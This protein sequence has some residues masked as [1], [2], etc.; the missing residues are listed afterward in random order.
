MLEEQTEVSFQQTCQ[1]C[2]PGELPWL[3]KTGW[4]KIDTQQ[5]SPYLE[6]LLDNIQCHI[7][8]R[9]LPGRSQALAIEIASVG[10]RNCQSEHRRPL[11]G[12]CMM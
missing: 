8:N 2:L 4:Y 3:A 9:I 1:L 5:F 10:N 12:N 7:F 6:T 11:T